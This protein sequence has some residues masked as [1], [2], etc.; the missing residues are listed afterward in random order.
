M[1]VRPYV[2]VTWHVQYG[3]LWTHHNAQNQPIHSDVY[4]IVT[5]DEF[6]SFSSLRIFSPSVDL[7]NWVFVRTWTNFFSEVRLTWR[8]DDDDISDSLIVSDNTS[9]DLRSQRQEWKWVSEVITSRTQTRT[10]STQQLLFPFHAPL[11]E[12]THW[13]RTFP[14]P[15]YELRVNA[16]QA[17]RGEA[18]CIR[19]SCGKLSKTSNPCIWWTFAFAHLH[20]LICRRADAVSASVHST[21]SLSTKLQ[22][23]IRELGLR[24]SWP[25]TVAHLITNCTTLA[26]TRTPLSN[27]QSSFYPINEVHNPS[28]LEDITVAA[29]K[30]SSSLHDEWRGRFRRLTRPQ[31]FAGGLQSSHLRPLCEPSHW[32]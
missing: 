26:P 3:F 6:W 12:P 4:S 11:Y 22:H 13:H 1:Y 7:I 25:L 9:T 14:I 32:G 28:G 10:L 30:D 21:S 27:R 18:L 23:C 16:K 24:N 20:H 2:Y 15:G 5:H 29:I 17:W 31:R 19:A 8:C